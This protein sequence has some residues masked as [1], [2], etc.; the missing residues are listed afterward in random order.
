MDLFQGSGEVARVSRGPAR[1]ECRPCL[2]ERPS[3]PSGK[4]ADT[5]SVGSICDR[6]LGVFIITEIAME[7][8]YAVPPAH[9]VPRT[10]K[11]AYPG[12]Q[13]CR[14][15][16]VPLT[17]LA[18]LAAWQSL[19]SGH[20]DASLEKPVTLWPSP[21]GTAERKVADTSAALRQSAGLP[22]AAARPTR[23]H[24]PTRKGFALGWLSAPRFTASCV[25]CILDQVERRGVV[26]SDT[27]AIIPSP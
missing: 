9:P 25:Q 23:K 6:D 4:V 7:N 16:R 26:G 5:H 8:T 12:L 21:I 2:L 19:C 15:P 10:P 22:S 18:R 1:S 24:G 3:E 13:R 17:C 11:V 14:A 20:V 27:A